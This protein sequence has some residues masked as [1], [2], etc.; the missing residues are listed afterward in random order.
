MGSY[1]SRHSTTDVIPKPVEVLPATESWST[2]DA[3]QATVKKNEH[4]ELINRSKTQK[5]LLRSSSLLKDNYKRTK[6]LTAISANLPPLE[7][8]SKVGKKH[9]T[10]R[11]NT[12]FNM[13]PTSH[14]SGESD[15]IQPLPH[16]EH[17]YSQSNLN[18]RRGTH[19]YEVRQAM[20]NRK[21]I[22]KLEHLF[23][24]EQ[25]QSSSPLEEVTDNETVVDDEPDTSQL[26][27][28]V[29][30]NVLVHKPHLTGNPKSSSQSIEHLE[31]R[32]KDTQQEVTVSE[33]LASAFKVDPVPPSTFAPYSQLSERELEC[34]AT[35]AE[36]TPLNPGDPTREE[37]KEILQQWRD[38]GLL[39][40]IE[41]HA[42]SPV[43]SQAT[44]ISELAHNLVT[45]SADYIKATEGND[46]HIQIAKA[47]CVY[48]WI[49]YNITYD[50]EH[51]K[52]SLSE[53]SGVKC[54]TDAEEVFNTRVTVCTGY[55]N[56]FKA[57]AGMCGLEVEVI[58][59]YAK[60]WKSLSEERPDADMPFKPTR[61]NA[62]TW[63]SVSNY[64][65]L[66]KE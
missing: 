9:V 4:H 40:S 41:A 44:T 27:E 8:Q 29:V 60:L 1:V 46:V 2:L 63:N 45:I 28:K 37:I 62:H 57:L 33:P 51:W 65:V 53:E 39:A 20:V 5:S 66:N 11:A 31:K 59:G 35:I 56:L 54:S 34:Q 47:Y 7:Q 43:Q 32:R 58:H 3:F 49:A 16:T 24:E 22:R 18:T 26:T 36:I 13:T 23:S 55:A 14:I 6:T 21:N 61:E 64:I 10:V 19:F 38:S 30:E 50:V 12:Q 15:R 25:N 48:V 17:N 52:L 42:L